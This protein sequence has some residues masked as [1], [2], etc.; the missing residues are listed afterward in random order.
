MAVPCDEGL[1]LTVRNATRRSPSQ[2]DRAGM[3]AVL[4]IRPPAVSPVDYS[5]SSCEAHKL[6]SKY[7]AVNAPP[8]PFL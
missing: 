5:P 8:H 7:P 4:T 2:P 6:V 3:P 1:A